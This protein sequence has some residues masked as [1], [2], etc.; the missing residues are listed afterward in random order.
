M[1]HRKSM[2]AQLPA[3]IAAALWESNLGQMVLAQQ[4]V[5]T[6]APNELAVRKVHGSWNPARARQL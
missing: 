4:R 6:P 5:P 1:S 3:M 2:R